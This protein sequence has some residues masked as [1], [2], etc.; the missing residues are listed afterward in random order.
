MSLQQLPWTGTDRRDP[1][2]RQRLRGRFHQEYVE[3]PGMSLTPEQAARL[4]ALPAD[5]CR[6]V[7]NEL[8]QHGALTRREDRYVTASTP[9]HH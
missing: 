4:F 9:G 1:A 3:L 8:V 6:R 2:G 7:L 5:M